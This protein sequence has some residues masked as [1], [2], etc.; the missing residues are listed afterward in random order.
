[1]IED[2]ANQ[3]VMHKRKVWP[4]MDQAIVVNL[5]CGFSMIPMVFILGEST[6]SFNNIPSALIIIGGTHDN[7]MTIGLGMSV[8]TD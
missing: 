2:I 6:C 5:V 3:Q 1:M 8:I 7:L 4:M